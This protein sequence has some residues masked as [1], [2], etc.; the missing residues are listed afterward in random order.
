MGRVSRVEGR[1][2]AHPEESSAGVEE[3]VSAGRDCIRADPRVDRLGSDCVGEADGTRL[4]SRDE[5]AAVLS[6]DT[7]AGVPTRSVRPDRFRVDRSAASR[8]D[9]RRFMVIAERPVK[10]SAA[11]SAERRVVE[12]AT[13]LRR[14]TPTLP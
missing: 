3:I 14:F 8:S 7:A 13:A 2:R 6:G 4:A 10:T 9:A 1:L 5:N 12:V 11:P